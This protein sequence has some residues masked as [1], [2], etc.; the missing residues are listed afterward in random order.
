M[1]QS[2]TDNK[3]RKWDL[4]LS[5]T[6]IKRVRSLTGVNI[7]ELLDRPA[8]LSEIAADPVTFV[9]VL[10]AIAKPQADAVNVTDEQFGEGLAGD[11]IERATES[12]LEA[13]VDFFPGARKATLRRVLSRAMQHLTTAEAALMTAL[14]DGSIDKAIDEALNV[15]AKSTTS[16]AVLASTPA[17]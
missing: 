4:S 11:S 8:M 16:P 7:L 13:L 14:A 17:A 6:T 15:S 10:Y 12:F 2:F 5:V 3:N 9:D 1:S